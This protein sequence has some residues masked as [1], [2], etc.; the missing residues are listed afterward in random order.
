MR[1]GSLVRRRQL[2]RILRELRQK[3]GM[4]IE[5][6]APLLDFS[7]SKLSR[8]E[9]AHQGVDV[10]AV[11]SMMD[12]F[13][14]GGERWGEIVELT[15]EANAKG[16]WR[17]YGLDD[18]GYVPLEAEAS[19]VRDYTV[20][21]VPG[22]LQTPAY[23][24]ALLASSLQRPSGTGLDRDVTVRMIRQERLTSP[25]EPLELLTVVEETA[26]HRPVGGAA[27]MRAQL[28]H[29][30]AAAALE[31]V[32]LQVL[33]TEVGAHPGING[34]FTVLSFDGLGEPDVGYVE[35]PV[36]SVHIE[37]SEHV[38][39]AR[40]VFGHLRSV[41]LSSPESVALVERVAAQL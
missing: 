2:A 1:S 21:H 13:G 37:K 5:T 34:A 35:H 26:L 8:I 29:L 16:W 39:R 23:A 14:V 41:A 11:R 30:A 12:V 19:A 28:D 15:R 17:A 18:Q 32:T 38:E 27:V 33:P 22:L 6:A 3:A 9:N 20:S 31:T 40:L 7:P 10:H 4:T 25:V 24:R 36:G